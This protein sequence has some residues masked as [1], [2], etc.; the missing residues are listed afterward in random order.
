M[1]INDEAS[2]AFIYDTTMESVAPSHANGLPIIGENNAQA[3]Q[4]IH[5]EYD[6][7]NQINNEGINRYSNQLEKNNQRQ[8]LYDLSGNQTYTMENNSVPNIMEN[9]EMYPEQRDSRNIEEEYVPNPNM[10]TYMTEQGYE[11]YSG[12]DPSQYEEEYDDGQQFNVITEQVEDNQTVSD[13]TRSD[14]ETSH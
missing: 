2:T 8:H 14:A 11:Q 13:R 12:Y 1:G 10:E 5:Q 6:T 9:T 3:L 4:M 7:S